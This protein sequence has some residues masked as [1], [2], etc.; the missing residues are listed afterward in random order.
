MTATVTSTGADAPLSVLDPSSTATGR[1]V[2]GSYALAQQLQAKANSGAFAPLRTDNGPLTLLSWTGPVSNEAVALGFKQTIGAAEGLRTGIVRQDADVHAVDDGAVDQHAE[3]ARHGAPSG[4]SVASAR[5]VPPWSPSIVDRVPSTFRAAYLIHGDDHGR[6]AERRARLRTMAETAAGTAGVEVYEADQCT[7]ENVAGALSAMTFAM[8]RRFVIADGVERWKESEVEPVAT[9]LA[10]ADPETLTVAFFAREEGRYKVPAKLVEAVEKAG[11]QI[12]AEMNVKAWDLPKWLAEQ[13]RALD[14][15]LDRDGAKALIS[16]VGDRQQRLLRELEKLAME[17][18]P[19]PSVGV[20]EVEESCATSAE[21]KVWTL[22]DALVAGDRKASIA[23]LLELREQG[24]RVTGL[25]YNMV[26]PAARRRRGR[27]G[28]AGGPVRLPGQEG[29]ADAAARR[30]QVRQGRLRPRRRGAAQGIGRDGR[31]RGREPWRRAQRGHRGRPRRP[32]RHRL[33]AS[34]RG[35]RGSGP[36]VAGESGPTARLAVPADR[37]LRLPVG[38]RDLRA[39]RSQRR[40]SNGCACRAMTAPACSARC[41]TAT[42]ARSGSAP[43]TRWSPRRA[44]TCR[45]R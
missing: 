13:A 36:N 32:H 8:G 22:A 31:P 3:G 1:L 39:R 24:E 30:G 7:T 15:E 44:A 40:R 17:H 38:L 11:G 18:G 25:I 12:A 14:L 19:A 33:A 2:N 23:L 6:I 9:A 35:L 42:P 20:D 21:R 5:R 26:A 43:P 34:A 4:R 41:W 29:P 28:V 27:R 16:Q 45:G 10:S 37:G